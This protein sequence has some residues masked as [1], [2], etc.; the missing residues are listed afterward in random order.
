MRS[1]R[2]EEMEILLPKADL[3]RELYF[4]QG[5]V[6]RKSAIPILSNT[7]IE[8]HGQELSFSAT[9]LD[10]SL[11]SECPAHV[12]AE[13]A[14]TVSTKKLYEIAR[15][16]PESDVT[17]KLLPDYWVAIESGSVVF[18]LAGL[19]K[20]DY[21]AL[22]QR[23]GAAAIEIDGEA[24]RDLTARTAFAISGEDARYY[25]AGALLVLEDGAA[26]LV[27]TDG[28]RLAY[29]R[30]AGAHNSHVSKRVLIP[31]KAVHEIG[32]LLEAGDKL[33]F[34]ESGNHLLF[35]VGK[36]TLASKMVEGQFPSF[37]NVIATK[38]DKKVQI[39]R[40]LLLT[41][42]RRVSLV[43]SDRTR[44][45]RLT[46]GAGVVTLAAASAELGEARETVAAEYDGAEVT[47]GFNAQ[48]LV[49]FLLTAGTETISIDLKNAESQGVF[50][51]VGEAPTDHCYI[52]MP[53][54]L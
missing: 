19:P 51:P 2:N 34:E 26:A 28:H 25:L 32:R 29:A 13:G 42:T 7:L 47:I 40:E 18:K 1:E 4:L 14:I 46:A 43:A 36:R 6:E 16:L 10:I 11:R 8:A 9:D 24:L 17:V 23:S 35:T 39:S 20:Q 5:I 38:G 30:R 52:V 53:M 12:V 48:Y 3:V 49:D 45:V 41:A 21:P 22:P 50:R 54:R 27:A 33:E 44:S 15:S 37:E 31:R